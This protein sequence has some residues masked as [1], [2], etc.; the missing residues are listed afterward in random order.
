MPV[1]FNEAPLTKD[2]TR[3]SSSRFHPFGLGCCRSFSYGKGCRLFES[4]NWC[5]P[6]C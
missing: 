3:P 2:K 6:V 4:P 5:I 1:P